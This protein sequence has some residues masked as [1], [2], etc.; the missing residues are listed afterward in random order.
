LTD[1]PSAKQ[2]YRRMID[3]ANKALARRNRALLIEATLGGCV[4]A[5]W[6]DPASPAP[7]AAAPTS[8]GAASTPTAT[9]A[10]PAATPSE[11][12]G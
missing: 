11:D 4:T 3:R 1:L 10:V 9:A 2:R 6:I 5:S 8:T 12:E 7:P